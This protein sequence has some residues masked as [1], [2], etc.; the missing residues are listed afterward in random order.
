MKNILMITRYVCELRK[1]IKEKS[2]MNTLQIYILIRSLKA[3]SDTDSV[4][5]S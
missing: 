2:V 4:Y 3:E 5:I 1:F